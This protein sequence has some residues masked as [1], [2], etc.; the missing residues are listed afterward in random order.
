MFDSHFCRFWTG[1]CASN[2]VG[3]EKGEIAVDLKNGTQCIPVRGE[4]NIIIWA[5]MLGRSLSKG[6]IDE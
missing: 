6:C 2:R 5:A 4:I 3:A 1:K